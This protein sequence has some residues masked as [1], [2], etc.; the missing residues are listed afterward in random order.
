MTFPLPTNVRL[1]NVE[2]GTSATGEGGVQLR[3]AGSATASL[4]GDDAALFLITG[5]ETL[6]LV[7]DPDAPGRSWETVSEV[8]GAGPVDGGPG[9]GVLVQFACP[10]DPA[11][12]SFAATATLTVSEDGTVV[13]HAIPVTATVL[14]E[15]LTVNVAETSVFVGHQQDIT[16]TISSTYRHDV[17]GFLTVAATPA[18]AFTFEPLQ[19]HPT[20]PR[21]GEVTVTFPITCVDTAAV[22]DS[23][24]DVT[25][26][27]VN[28]ADVASGGANIRVLAHRTVSVASTFIDQLTLL[29]PSSTTESLA[30]TV[31]HGPGTIF[32]ETIG[33]PESVSLAMPQSAVVDGSVEVPVTINVP[34]TP[35]GFE[36]APAPI[37]LAWIVPA[38]DFHPEDVR[39]SLVLSE[40]ALPPR[41]RQVS[42]DLGPS[43]SSGNAT[44]L[45]QQDGLVSFQGHVHDSGPFGVTY[46]FA[47][48]FLDVHDADGNMV[49]FVHTGKMSGTLG[50]GDTRSDDWNDSGPNDPAMV[51]FISDH[52][53]EFAA[54]RVQSRMEVDTDPEQI[55]EVIVAGLFAV[56]IVAVIGLWA[57]G[58]ITVTCKVVP[59]G[60][61][62]SFGIG[63]VCSITPAK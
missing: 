14:P 34:S 5:L 8:D 27:P 25:M 31:S 3:V 2:P 45:I 37:T 10:D 59:G 56:G 55:L 6:A 60:G 4:S 52:W 53:D 28:N 41:W 63:I 19:G 22:G 26:T 16:V 23:R 13:T 33:I 43:N 62:D 30:V 18:G 51:A 40:V 47:M 54:S 11:K 39:G 7:K 48:A 57:T 42:A 46:V 1:T 44:I 20:V 61:S 36:D 17:A 12:E 24:L 9:F 38:D 29:H 35:V 50:G 58:V 15:Q 32:F 49:V 21:L